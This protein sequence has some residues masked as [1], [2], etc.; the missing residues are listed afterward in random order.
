MKK[1]CERCEKNETV[2]YQDEVDAIKQVAVEEA[3]TRSPEQL[4]EA[5]ICAEDS[6]ISAAKKLIKAAHYAA[7]KARQ[8]F[9]VKAESLRGQ[10]RAAIQEAEGVRHSFEW[11]LEHGTEEIAR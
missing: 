11:L 10:Y 7:R 3:L 2:Y 1:I 8:P 6:P 9:D 5:V 4:A